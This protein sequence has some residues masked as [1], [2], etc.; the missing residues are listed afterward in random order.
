MADYGNKVLD[1][2]LAEKL[3]AS[4]EVQ[5]STEDGICTPNGGMICVFEH[6]TMLSWD[7]QESNE[8]QT[9]KY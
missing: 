8:R 6:L 9:F 1:S 3:S 7:L 4:L 5:C 2:Q